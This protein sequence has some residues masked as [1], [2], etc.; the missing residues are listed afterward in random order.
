MTYEK[1]GFRY[2]RSP[3]GQ[4][5]GLAFSGPGFGASSFALGGTNA[6]GQKQGLG[7]RTGGAVGEAA[8]WSI[9]PHVAGVAMLPEL[10][11]MAGSLAK[12]F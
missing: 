7:K 6:A 10:A 8:L 4:V 1:E 2:K 9:A 11:T 5:G 3:I 12:T